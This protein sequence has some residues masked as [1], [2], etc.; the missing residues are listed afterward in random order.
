MLSSTFY[1]CISL[2]NIFYF[3]FASIYSVYQYRSYYP[4]SI[5]LFKIIQ[6]QPSQSRGIL[7]LH[8][9]TYLG[10]QILSQLS[11]PL[12]KI[13]IF[14]DC[15]QLL[16]QT[17][18]N[19]I[20]NISMVILALGNVRSHSKLNSFRLGT[21]KPGWCDALLKSPAHYMKNLLA[22]SL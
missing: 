4:K 20:H 1:W 8:K 11:L 9:F 18:F 6:K 19:L 21:K 14:Q 16:C 15:H 22:W 7:I 5:Q 12:F 17:P 13:V 2:V 3:V 10:C